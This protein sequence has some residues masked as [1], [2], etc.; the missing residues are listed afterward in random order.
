MF[1]DIREAKPAKFESS[2][3]EEAWYRCAQLL[4]DL[5]LNEFNRPD[6]A[7][8]C[9]LEFRTSSKSGA[10][11]LYKL[12]QAYEN[13]GDMPRAA[14]YYEQVTGYTEHPRYYDAQ[15]SLRRVKQP[16]S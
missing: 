1:E 12:G 10:D 6:L 4:G 2:A 15:E 14:Y 8:P 16:Q 5:Y 9:Y 11:T 13:L 3:D 7:V